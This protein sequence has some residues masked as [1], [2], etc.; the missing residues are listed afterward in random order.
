M[1]RKKT[2]YLY[3]HVRV[4][5]CLEFDVAEYESY[6]AAA[7]GHFYRKKYFELQQSGV[8]PVYVSIRGEGVRV[9]RT[10]NPDSKREKL[11]EAINAELENLAAQIADK[12]IAGIDP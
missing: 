4:P 5:N 12:V 8:E 2:K 3:F 10:L 9:K 1:S 11:R 6:V 7:I